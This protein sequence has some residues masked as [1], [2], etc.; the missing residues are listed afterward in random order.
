MSQMPS[1]YVGNKM[2]AEQL[3]DSVNI[4]LSLQVSIFILIKYKCCLVITDPHIDVDLCSGVECKWRISSMGTS[5]CTGVVRGDFH[6]QYI[7][8][9]VLLIE[10][11]VTFFFRC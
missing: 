5:D 2:V 11:T 3:Y 6:S 8:L 7:L 10:Y 4:I 1:K 9:F